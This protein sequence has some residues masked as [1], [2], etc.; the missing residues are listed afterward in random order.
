MREGFGTG[1]TSKRTIVKLYKTQVFNASACESNFVRRLFRSFDQFLFR[2]SSQ[3]FKYRLTSHCDCDLV[4]AD[5]WLSYGNP[6]F[7]GNLGLPLVVD[8]VSLLLQRVFGFLNFGSFPADIQ[9][10]IVFRCSWPP[11]IHSSS[12]LRISRLPVICWE[13]QA[14]SHPSFWTLGYQSSVGDSRL[15][16][17]LPSGLQAT[18][19]L[20]R[21]LGYQSSFLLDSRLPIICWGL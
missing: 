18:N 11:S 10:V 7:H 15:P 19:H 17:I 20:L 12:M 21:T 8:V 4:V 16:I 5:L 3:Y 9:L 13:L 14:I 2:M 6:N 1:Y